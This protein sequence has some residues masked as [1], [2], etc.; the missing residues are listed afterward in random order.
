MILIPKYRLGVDVTINP[1]S[2]TLPFSVPGR[3][4]MADRLREIP[5]EFADSAFSLQR[6]WT[7][8]ED[9]N[10]VI[11][12]FPL[13]EVNG[14]T[15]R[16][17]NDVPVSFES[18]T[19]MALRIEKLDPEEESSGLCT[20]TWVDWFTG[21]GAGHTIGEG[22]FLLGEYAATHDVTASTSLEMDFVNMVNRRAQ[23]ILIG[24]GS[25]AGTYT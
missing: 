18:L 16:N 5:A 19:F 8:E 13:M 20:L 17:L 22:D 14:V 24:V 11:D 7:T 25:T 9:D 10:I 4:F 21:D 2:T 1:N 23:L 15:Q 6:E 12:T 3:I